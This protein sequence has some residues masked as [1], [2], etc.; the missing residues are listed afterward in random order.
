MKIWT[1]LCQHQQQIDISIASTYPA[2]PERT[3]SAKTASQV[4]SP[5]AY[6][7]MFKKKEVF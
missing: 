1:R 5:S 2:S 4:L 3:C 7:E 6:A